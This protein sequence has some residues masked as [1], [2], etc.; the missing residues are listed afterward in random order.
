MIKSATEL[1]ICI[2]YETVCPIRIRI[3]IRIR[4]DPGFFSDPDPGSGFLKDLDP[5]NNDFQNQNK[6]KINYAISHL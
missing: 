1:M 2:V 5:G 3:Q 4:G 6:V